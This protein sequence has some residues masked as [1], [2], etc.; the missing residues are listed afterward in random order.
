MYSSQYIKLERN[1]PFGCFS[2]LFKKLYLEESTCLTQKKCIHRG[3]FSLSSGIFTYAAAATA[4]VTTP[5]RREN[6]IILHKMYVSFPK[7]KIEATQHQ[8]LQ[9]TLFNENSSS[10]LNF[11]CSASHIIRK[12]G[13]TLCLN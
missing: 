11:L 10:R 3:G 12:R 1:S 4:V 7:D 13:M 2:L 5:H 9:Q 8:V 6:A